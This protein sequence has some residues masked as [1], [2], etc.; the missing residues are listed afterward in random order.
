MTSL[1]S[2]IAKTLV[3]AKRENMKKING[4]EERLSDLEQLM[5]ETRRLEQEQRDLAFAF[6]VSVIKYITYNMT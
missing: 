1:Q 2:E 3:D 5:C 4:L 6:Q